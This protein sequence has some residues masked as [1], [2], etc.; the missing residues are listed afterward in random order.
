MATDR[1]TQL[2]KAAYEAGITS[3]RELANFMAQVSAESNGL[4][5][6]NEGFRYTKGP[7]AV[8][9]N[10]RSALREGPE[11]LSAA[12]QEAMNGQPEKLAELMYGGRMGNSE[13]G[14]G[15]KYH[16][17][18]YIQLTGK[19][20]YR[21]AGDALDL[22]L[23]NNPELAAQPENAAR[24]A[25]WYWKEN[26][27]ALAPESV[28]EAGSIINTGELGNTPNGLKHREAEFAKWE[29]ALTPELMQ[30]L[31]EGRL[32]E[33]VA[34]PQGEQQQSVRSGGRS[35]EDV[36][37]VMLPPQNGI[38]P[39]MTSDFGPRTLNGRADDHGGV[40]FNYRG[41]Q[42][43]IN[44]RNPVVHS[45]VAGTVEV[46]PNSAYGTVG[47]RD[48]QGNLHQVLHLDSRSVQNGQQVGVG[49]P[50]GRMGGRGPRGEDQY[51]Q[52]VHYQIRDNHGQ[53]VDP[54]AFWNRQ[55]D[56]AGPHPGR[57]NASTTDDLLRTGETGQNVRD[58]QQ[59]LHRLGYTT[60]AGVPLP[61][62]GIFGQDTE[63]A[64]RAFQRDHGLKEDGIVGPRTSG[65]IRVQPLA[66]GVLRHRET[67]PDIRGLQQ[68][69]NG[70]GYTDRDGK[71][72]ALDGNY[73]LNTEHAVR[74]FQRD[75]GLKVDG[76]AGPLTLEA[77]GKQVQTGEIRIEQ[78]IAG[79]AELGNRNLP[80]YLR[81]L[82]DRVA[83]AFR[84]SQ[85]DIGSERLDQV[86]AAVAVDMRKLGLTRADQVLLVP[87][88][89]GV[90]GP[91]SG[92]GVQQGTYPLLLRSFT[93][94]GETP[95]LQESVR[96]LAQLDQTPGAE[97]QAVR[98]HA[99]RFA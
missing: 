33:G 42:T 24:I 18:G 2:L 83:E 90:F 47:I 19:D 10:V 31:S 17:R 75:H 62:D 38:A 89:G 73:G 82:R 23:I 79:Q 1:E 8:A 11:A 92:V 5:R 88:S 48:A 67:G 64:V 52:H 45:P 70:L 4:N 26:V 46:P 25:I 81:D 85:I 54:E 80:D 59:S 55:R 39:H 22:D 44:L 37:R 60:R 27:Q 63:H 77:V 57:G 29:R 3:P 68:G 51:A 56:L 41:G 99:E 14:E 15:Y 32:G 9:A 97:Q 13:P 72:L 95:T 34:A 36:M 87:G 49:D 16:G 66:D 76:I 69:L 40:D 74:A 78:G 12:W 96:Q 98:Q 84:Q 93:P 58:L 30:N 28:K 53:I 7:D 65:A 35:F 20:Q 86:T 71:P 94:V 21:A 43:G 91:D 50:I 61:I 6:L